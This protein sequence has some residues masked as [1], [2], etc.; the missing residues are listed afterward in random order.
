MP[1]RQLACVSFA[2]LA[3]FVFQRS[4]ARAQE[5]VD[6]AATFSIIA[7]DPEKKEW[8]VAVASKYIAV[9]AVVP[10]ARAGVGAVATQ[11]A[12]NISYGPKGLDLM[13]KGKTAEEA[14]Q[15]L[16][17]EDKAKEYRQVAFI[18][19]K[20]NIFRFTGK[21][22]NDWAGDRVGKNYSIQGNLL[23]GQK[24]IDAMADAFEK[25]AGPLA[26]R[27]MASLE[28]GDKAGGDKRGKQ[29]AAI[30]V[31]RDRAG[32]NGIGDRYLDLRVDDHKEPVEELSRILSLRVRRP[33]GKD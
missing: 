16:L 27:L 17:E 2:I 31:V 3:T 32:P 13:E 24:V 20:G 33:K 4:I 14:M 28:A 23:A 7:Y 1:K 18:D 12:V 29:A 5:P 9:G 15:M 25:Q 10:H 11:S 21:K 26:W 6:R 22:C 8:G 30:L 19:G